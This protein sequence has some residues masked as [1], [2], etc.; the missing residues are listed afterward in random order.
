MLSQLRSLLSLKGQDRGFTLIELLIVVLIVGIL[1]AVGV[2]L[3]FGYI[4]DA[5]SVEAKS[6]AGALWTTVQANAISN[7]GTA[8]KVTD[9]Y[10]RAGFDSAGVTSDGRWT[11][12]PGSDTTLPCDTGLFPDKDVFTIAGSKAD[13][14]T[15][16]VKLN[17]TIAN[18]PA[19]Q[20]Q[21]SFTGAAGTYTK[22]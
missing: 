2:P 15:L 20:L 4:N 16:A 10:A 22:C 7:C 6:V 13:N 18:T 17:Y 5:K 8:S 14:S 12:T 11:T 21:C 9:A 3:Y 19:S 1:A